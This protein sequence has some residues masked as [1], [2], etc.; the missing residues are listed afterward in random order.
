MNAQTTVLETVGKQA[1]G[2]LS[3]VTPEA[4]SSILRALADRFSEKIMT[5]AADEART[6]EEISSSERIPLSTC[7]RRMQGLVDAGLVV[8]DKVV[9]TGSGKRY[10]TYRSCYRSFRISADSHG[11]SVEVELN[12]DPVEKMRNRQLLK[13]SVGT[14][15]DVA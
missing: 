10:A 4:G 13:S 14:S 2:S 1:T 11:T 15:A 5:R 6:V 3:S 9:I 7:Y 8:V 12:K